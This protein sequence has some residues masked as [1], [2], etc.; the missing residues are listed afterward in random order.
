[1]E[2]KK[3]VFITDQGS[4]RAKRKR[5]LRVRRADPLEL[6]AATAETPLVKPLE[7]P[8]FPE[9]DNPLALEAESPL[10][11]L[12]LLLPLTALRLV[13]TLRLLA[14]PGLVERLIPEAGLAPTPD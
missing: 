8:N 3:A 5:A 12:L 9:L 2:N 11:L 13:A 1:M 14:E 4:R 7:L 6:G 10:E